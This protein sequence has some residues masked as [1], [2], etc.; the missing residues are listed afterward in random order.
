MERSKMRE[1][2]FRAWDIK[3]KVMSFVNEHGYF[4]RAYESDNGYWQDTNLGHM[5]KRHNE[6]NSILMQY[7]GLKDKN[8][9]GGFFKDIFKPEDENEELYLI[10]WFKDTASWVLTGLETGKVR[11]IENREQFRS[12][13]QINFSKGEIIGNI[14]E[15]PEL[16][17]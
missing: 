8:G 15:N 2:K 4:G 11:W 5:L 12:D 1:L 6:G 9:K 7:T 14:Y 17:K 13:F 16:L 10:D 3:S